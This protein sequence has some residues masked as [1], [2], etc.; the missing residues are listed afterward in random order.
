V[1]L[2]LLRGAWQERKGPVVHGDYVF[3][4]EG[5]T[6]VYLR[7]DRKG[8]GEVGESGRGSSQIGGDADQLLQLT[9]PTGGNARATVR[10][11]SA[12]GRFM[13]RR[14]GHR[15]ASSCLAQGWQ[16]TDGGK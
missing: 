9:R 4:A 5:L 16:E 1:L 3:Y 11:L 8:G 13:D 15:D 14:S 7:H 6:V 2:E 10:V 12:V